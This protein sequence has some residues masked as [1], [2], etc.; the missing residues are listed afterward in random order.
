MR[1]PV[2][3][4]TSGVNFCFAKTV[5]HQDSCR[6]VGAHSP[7][8]KYNIP[9]GA[10]QLA[11][12][13]AELPERDVDSVGKR[14]SKSLRFF[15]DVQDHAVLGDLPV[16]E[17]GESFQDVLRGEAGHVDR[18]FGRG[19]RRGIGQLEILEVDHAG[20]ETNC[21]SDRVDALVHAVRADDLG[22]EYF[23][24]VHGEEELDEHLHCTGVVARMGAL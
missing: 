14:V 5:L 9:C 2:E 12:S 24:A 23:G 11:E 3:G 10:V 6:I 13:C 21:C 8:A 16:G 19:E 7:L 1:N 15:S 17:A 22:P 4:G 20:A 18:V